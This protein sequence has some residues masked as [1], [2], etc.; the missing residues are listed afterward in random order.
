PWL[1]RVA[2]NRIRDHVRASQRAATATDDDLLD[3]RAGAAVGTGA[4]GRASV[5]DSALAEL[6][7]ALSALGDADRQV[8][9]LRH[10]AG[11]SFAAMADLLDEPLGTLLARHHRALKK[12]R[13]MMSDGA[14]MRQSVMEDRT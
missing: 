11:L 7:R 10:H 9:E 4:D 6:R 14:G 13:D 8:I 3:A 12:L 1:F 5:A 2:V